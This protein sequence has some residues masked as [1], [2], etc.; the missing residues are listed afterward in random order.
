ME[1]CP[2]KIEA[3]MI[4]PVPKAL[5]PTRTQVSRDLDVQRH[6][7]FF[8]RLHFAGTHGSISLLAKGRPEVICVGRIRN[9]SALA[10][11]VHKRLIGE[12]A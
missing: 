10:D 2:A 12:R 11:S 4:D 6:K 3:A 5:M 1:E 9:A 8:D 7:A